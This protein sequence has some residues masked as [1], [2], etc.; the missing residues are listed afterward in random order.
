MT[1]RSVSFHS[2]VGGNRN[3]LKRL[4]SGHVATSEEL[5][6]ALLNAAAVGNRSK[7]KKLIDAGL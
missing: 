5:G 1:D 7:L 6:E 4:S 2:G 3:R